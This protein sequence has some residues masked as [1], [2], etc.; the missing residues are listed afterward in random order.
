MYRRT[1]LKLPLLV[2]AGAMLTRVPRA[3]AATSRWTAD[4]AN[5]WYQSQGWLVGSNY[6]P[7]TAINQLE[8]FQANTFDA[9]RINAELNWARLCGLNTMRVFLH[10]QLWA[11]D[12]RGFQTRLSQ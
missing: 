12:R 10:D 6:L 5:R 11:A 8:M 4:Q 7:A 3:S 2:G 9:Q 1:A